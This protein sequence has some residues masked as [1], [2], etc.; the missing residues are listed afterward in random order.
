M[1]FYTVTQGRIVPPTWALLSP[2]ISEPPARARYS[3][4]GQKIG[5]LNMAEFTKG[6]YAPGPSMEHIT[7]IHILSPQ[8]Q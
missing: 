7:Y 4:S 1:E 8:A 3:A 5:Q 6:Y 2:G